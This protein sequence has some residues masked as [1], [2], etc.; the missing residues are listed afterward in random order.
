MNPVRYIA[1]GFVDKA[2]QLLSYKTERKIIVIESDDWGNAGVS[3]RAQYDRLLGLGL[4]LQRSL[5]DNFDTLANSTDLEMLFGVLSKYR[6]A[7]GCAPIITANTVTANPDYEKI[8]QYNFERYYFEPFTQTL[9]RL[10]AEHSSAFELWKQGMASGVFFPQFHGRE[11][12]NVAL[13]MN[14]LRKGDNT[15]TRVAFDNQ[16]HG[17]FT[18]NEILRA[19]SREML[20]YQSLDELESTNRALIQGLDLF[21]N[22]FG[23][24]S[25]SFIAPRYV[26]SN[27]NEKV[28]HA[29][30][31]Q[32]IQGQ[33]T[34]LIPRQGVD[35]KRK[36]LRYTGQCNSLG[37]T[38]LT[39][40]A[41][42]EPVSDNN[43]TEH[44]LE[45]VRKAFAAKTPAIISTHRINFM[46]H[47]DPRNRD[48]GLRQFDRLLS[49]IVDRYPNVEFL[50]SVALGKLIT[51]A[52]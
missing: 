33:R 32:Y 15:L 27:A 28:L 9:S 43:A 3:S 44:C 24:R 14:E 13:W 36:R 51:K 39:R 19:R 12:L 52:E 50:S 20:Y 17:V 4:P 48:N 11:H 47:L 29:E 1:K 35:A 25:E 18:D 34:Q 37:Q 49:S 6:D 30:G 5:Y 46:G 31:V 16:I 10:S 8:R 40:N 38:Q 42:F 2:L 21:E 22:I 7:T 23:Y 45:M 41:F 26:W